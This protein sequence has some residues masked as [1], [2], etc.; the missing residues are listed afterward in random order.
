M[1]GKDENSLH[2]FLNSFHICWNVSNDWLLWLIVEI[3]NNNMISS[4]AE[5]LYMNQPIGAARNSLI[6]ISS[7][8]R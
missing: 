7:G 4:A 5:Y 6:S 2:P 3:T 8:E 1:T